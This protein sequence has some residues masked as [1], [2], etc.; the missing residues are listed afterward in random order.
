MERQNQSSITN[1]NKKSELKVKSPKP[2]I[3]VRDIN[4]MP[5][6][7]LLPV[8]RDQRSQ[9][10][11]DV[12]LRKLSGTNPIR[13]A[14]NIEQSIQK[15]RIS[16]YNDCCA[17]KASI[18]FVPDGIILQLAFG[19]QQSSISSNGCDFTKEPGRV[20]ITTPLIMDGVCV[21]FRGWIDMNTLDGFG[22]LEF[23]EERALIE[24]KKLCDFGKNQTQMEIELEFQRKLKAIARA[25]MEP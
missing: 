1:M 5:R 2:V 19:H 12:L 11:N 7:S 20:Y 14:E 25:L 22:C 18:G 10:E 23:D 4:K 13:Y 9:F 3:Y 15:R 17:G 16:F 6:P 8:V 24:H 21:K